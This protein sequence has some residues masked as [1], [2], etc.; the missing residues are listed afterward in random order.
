[1]RFYLQKHHQMVQKLLLGT[2][3]FFATQNLVAQSDVTI[4]YYI[5]QEGSE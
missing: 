2:L 5:A 1:M 4:I 3:S